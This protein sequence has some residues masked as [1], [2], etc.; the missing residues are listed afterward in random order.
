MPEILT[1]FAALSPWLRGP[2]LALLGAGAALGQAPWDMP[3]A[4]VLALVAMF[5]LP[6]HRKRAGFF[7]G[8][9]F[10]AGYFGLA[11][12]WITRPFMVDA[13]R[14]GWMAPF[15][16]VFMAAGLALFWGGAFALAR[17]LGGSK[18]ALVAC[19][20]GAEVARSLLFTGFPWAVIGHIW[21]DTPLAQLAAYVGPHGL[22]LL[23]FAAVA[24]VAQVRLW[25]LSP[26]LLTAAG[27]WALD[28][29]SAPSA[30]PAA[31]LIRLVQPNVPQTEKWDADKI[32]LH[33]QRLL[34]L[35]AAN[36]APGLVIW[37]ETAIP[38][39]LDQAQ[40]A[41]EASAIAA[42]GAPLILGV[43][44][45]DQ[46][47]YF[48]SLALLDRVGTVTAIYDKSHLVPFGEYMPLGEVMARFGIHGLASSEG[49]G[50]SAGVSPELIEVPDIGPILPLICYEGIFAEEVN[51]VQGR[52]RLMVLITNDAWFGTDSGPYQHFALARL[53]AIEQ[54]LPLARVANTGVSG[55]IDAQGRVLGQIG[56][57]QQG[58]VDLRLP[59]ALPPTLYVRLGDGPVVVLLV[60]LGLGLILRRI[61]GAWRFT[62]DP[63]GTGD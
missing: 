33:F 53:R 29:G 50:F 30:D 1:R 41:L 48:N 17:A 60:L 22:T 2:V 8:W 38:W 31:P 47:R 36:P 10:G 57:G 12:H 42:R 45:R 54:G 19:W 6:A 40:G 56:L 5:A 55:M 34:D 28:P 63:I 20:T 24:V 13:A 49:G 46:G 15:A 14:D 18:L 52:A 26:V 39:I 58:A 9:A 37:P 27:W 7:N 32:P 62:V 51:A 3:W 16:L 43:Q 23:T 44:R 35:S 21:I 61:H 4:T 25:S 59:P 11:L